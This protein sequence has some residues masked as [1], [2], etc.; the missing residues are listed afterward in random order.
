MSSEI[1]KTMFFSLQFGGETENIF[2]KK[3]KI[4]WYL[5]KL[6]IKTSFLI[7]LGLNYAL[8]IK[9]GLNLGL[10]YHKLSCEALKLPKVA[11]VESLE[12]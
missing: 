12:W 3:G 1:L 4:Q 7:K 11:C 8:V 9:M 2:Y 6:V 10:S 5:L